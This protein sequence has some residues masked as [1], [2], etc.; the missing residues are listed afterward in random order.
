MQIKKLM[1]TGAIFT[2][3][4]LVQ[5]KQPIEKRTWKTIETKG[6]MVVR[7]ENSAVYYKGQYM[8]IGSYNFV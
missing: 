5:A 7:E 3:V 8:L 2:A 4:A 1:I 6:D